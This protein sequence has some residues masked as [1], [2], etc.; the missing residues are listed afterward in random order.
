MKD[1]LSCL[2][3]LVL[4]FVFLG[5]I[6]FLMLKVSLWFGLLVLVA[7]VVFSEM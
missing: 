5:V 4:G 6:T 3:A 7:I 2:G 1:F